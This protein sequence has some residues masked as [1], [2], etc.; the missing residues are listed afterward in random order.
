MLAATWKIVGDTIMVT[1]MLDRYND[2]GQTALHI[3]EV[4]MHVEMADLLVTAGAQNLPMLP[5]IVDDC[6]NTCRT[7]HDCQEVHYGS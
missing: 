2:H 1:N 6:N 4:N 3:A 5:C 7:P